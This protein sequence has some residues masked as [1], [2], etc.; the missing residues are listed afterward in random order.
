MH[1]HLLAAYESCK[2]RF[3]EPITFDGFLT[4]TKDWEYIPVDV[5]GKCAGAIMHKGNEF[6]VCIIEKFHKRWA[7]KSLYKHIYTD[8]LKQYGEIFT[9]VSANNEIGKR[10][11]ERCGFKVYDSYANVVIY[12]LGG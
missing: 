5:G 8:K 2:D 7:S 6:H 12:R 4:L 10:F 1:S 9:S 11:V 3:D